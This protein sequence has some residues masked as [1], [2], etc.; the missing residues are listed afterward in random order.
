VPAAAYIKSQSYVPL[1]LSRSSHFID[2]TLRGILES[3]FTP[4]D[5]DLH[6]SNLVDTPILAIHGGED[7]NVPVWNT[8]ELIGILRAWNPATNVK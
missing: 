5:N 1:T 2:P 4:D 3:S 7:E 8:R 6:I